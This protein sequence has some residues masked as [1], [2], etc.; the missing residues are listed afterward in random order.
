MERH[1]KANSE[2]LVLCFD[3]VEGDGAHVT[4]RAPRIKFPSWRQLLRTSPNTLDEGIKREASG[5]ATEQNTSAGI[6]ARWEAGFADTMR[7]LERRPRVAPIDPMAGVAV[8][9]SDIPGS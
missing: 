7:M 9:D 1:P 6:H 8:Y 3:T 5:A 2:W 4:N